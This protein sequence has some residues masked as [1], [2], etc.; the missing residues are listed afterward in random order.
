[1]EIKNHLENIPDTPPSSAVGSMKDATIL[2]VDDDIG[3]GGFV[4]DACEEEGAT[5]LH[6]QTA[7]AA[8]EAASKKQYDIAIIDIHLPDENGDELAVDFKNMHSDM[9]VILITGNPDQAKAATMEKAGIES[10][11]TK[12]FSITQLRFT[13]L[14]ELMRRKMLI[15]PSPITGEESGLIGE[16]PFILS[17]RSQVA[18][19]ARGDMPVLIQGPTGTGKEVIA[20][21]IHILSNRRDRQMIT[22]NCAAIAEHLEESE[23]FGYAKGAFTGANSNKEGIVQHAD[24]STLFLDEVGELSMTMQ[25][26]LLRL[27]DVQEY[28]RIG[29]AAPHKVNVRF[30][31]ATNRDLTTMIEQG[32]FRSDLFFRLKAGAITTEPLIRH[33]EDIPILA[34]RFLGEYAAKHKARLR[35]VPDAMS[36]FVS[37]DWPGNVRQLKNVI[38]TLVA[39]AGDSGRISRAMV[40][41]VL[42]G[43]QTAQP[44]TPE[45]ETI[46]PFDK[47]REEFEKNYFIKIL[48][49]FE[50]N[51][52]HAARAAGM[53][54]ANFSKKA[55]S[56]GLDGGNFKS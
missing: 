37:S 48:M 5:V 29:D 44:T 38:E 56:M 36:T 17:I 50:G 18:M 21:A 47:A 11:L 10:L 16:S 6:V 54:R 35:F 23:F 49:K 12:P 7:S 1:M 13:V 40:E 25:A 15:V 27:L 24:G 33:K 22:V 3:V 32:R 8:R 31:S 9:P 14:R 52:T 45:D 51:M 41:T 43:P 30:I 53:D 55:K 19:L 20:R 28:L 2:I 34:E 39:V 42:G 46:P 4:A 26:K